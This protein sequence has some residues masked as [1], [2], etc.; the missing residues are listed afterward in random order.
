MDLKLNDLIVD[1][2]GV[3]TNDIFDSWKWCLTGIN[4]VLL[5]SKMGDMFLLGKDMGVYWLAVDTGGTLTK[6]AN[7]VKEFEQLLNNYDNVD[8]WFL[9]SLVEE[10]LEARITLNKN[11]V[12]SYKLLP[13]M[14]GQY[15]I[16]N[17]LPINIKIHFKYNGIICEQIK[18][19]PDGTHVKIVVGD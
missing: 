10:L 14:G 9:P 8:N 12:Y 2:T 4:E 19:L 18:D 5:V 13:V 17:I 11:E 1:I 7:G 3:D 15:K 6:I 16:D